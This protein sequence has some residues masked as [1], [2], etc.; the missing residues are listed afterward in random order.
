MIGL[1]GLPGTIFERS[2]RALPLVRLL[3]FFG[4]LLGI[5]QLV[6]LTH[7]YPDYKLPPPR[8]VWDSLRRNIENGRL[9][10]AIEVTMKR[11]G[12]GY[13]IAFVI[14][15]VIGVASGASRWVD[16]TIGNLCLGMQS[17]PSVIWLAPAILWFGLND[18][19]IVF[20]V[21]MGSTFAIAISARDGVRNI[22]PLLQRAAKTFGARNWQLYRFVVVPAM[23]PSLVQG[24]KLGWSFSWR[25]LMAGEL[26][27]AS[28]GLGQLLNTGRDLND[29]SLVMAVMFVIVAIGLAVDRVI[30]ASLE[31]WVRDRWGLS[32]A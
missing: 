31:A 6:A 13:T 29:I 30:F 17:L 23:L 5:W 3:I 9:Q 11:L 24:L 21:V 4:I 25:S 10:D 32:Q 28:G 2:R 16:E 18:H 19:A 7:H 26:I 27:F 8:D 22:P 15:M 14:G 12:Y 1:G 20:V